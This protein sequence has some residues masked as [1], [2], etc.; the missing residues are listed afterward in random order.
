MKNIF[1]T[2][3]QNKIMEQNNTPNTKGWWA[4]ETKNQETKSG[5]IHNLIIVDESGSMGMIYE[6]A[7]TGMNE[8]L[9]SIRSDAAEN[10]ETVHEV[11]LV[12]FDTAHYKEIFQSTPVGQTRDLTTADYRPCGGTPLFDAIGKAV[13]SL[14]KKVKQGENVLV[15][16]ITDG[17]ENASC[18]YSS[19][20]IKALVEELSSKGWLFSYIG[21]NQDAMAVGNSISIKASMNFEAS[22]KGM[23]D[24]WDVERNAR[25]KFYEVHREHG[26]DAPNI[27]N[28][29]NFFM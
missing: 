11:T 8:T 15:T 17:M 5:K 16:I 3:K 26:A 18:E 24:M 19:A 23:A 21:A 20:D 7:L 14:R 25:K 29:E 6:A 12:T 1:K 13:T 27:L 28:D 9:G 2:Q 22:D 4:K 10:P